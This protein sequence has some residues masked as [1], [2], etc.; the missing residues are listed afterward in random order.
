[1]EMAFGIDSG[2]ASLPDN[3]KTISFRTLLIISSHLY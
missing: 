1:M 3:C 2:V